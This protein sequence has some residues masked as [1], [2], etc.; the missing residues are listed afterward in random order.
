MSRNLDLNAS[1][2]PGTGDI[3][4]RRATV[5]TIATESSRL[6]KDGAGL[7]RGAGIVAVV[8]F[9]IFAVGQRYGKMPTRRGVA[10]GRVQGVRQ[11]RWVFLLLAVVG[12]LMMAV[13][14]L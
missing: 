2:L 1:D 5:L 13:S 10:Y 7:A 6:F 4:G 14:S 8:F 3:E 12:L 9:V 11:F